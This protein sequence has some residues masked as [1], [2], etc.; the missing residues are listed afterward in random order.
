MGEPRKIPNPDFSDDPSLYKYTDIGFVGFDVY[1]VKGGTIFDN[2]IITDTVSEADAFAQKWKELSN[3]E[4]A[5][6]KKD[7]EGEEDAFE[8]FRAARA[9]RAAAAEALKKE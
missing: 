5:Q 9:A 3:F 6:K 4:N 7:A 1:Q 2:I 8:K